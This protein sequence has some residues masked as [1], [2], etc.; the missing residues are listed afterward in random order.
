MEQ[1]SVR[2]LLGKRLKVSRALLLLTVGM[3]LAVISAGPAL[4][5]PADAIYLESLWPAHHRLGGGTGL[6]TGAADQNVAP[7]LHKYDFEFALSADLDLRRNFAREAV[8]KDLMDG[9]FPLAVGFVEKTTTK[10]DW[11]PFSGTSLFYNSTV[12]DTRNFHDVLM[13]STQSTAMGFSQGFGGGTSA[14]TMS[15]SRAVDVTSEPLQPERRSETEKFD[16]ASGLA[17]GWDLKMHLYTTEDNR[18]G[19][20]HQR[21]Y[22]AALQAPMSG[23]AG[24]LALTGKRTVVNQAETKNYKLD[25]VAPFAVRGGKAFAEHHVDYQPGGKQYDKYIVTKFG[26]PLGLFGVRGTIEHTIDETLK[27]ATLTEARTTVVNA[28]FMVDG[29]EIGHTQTMR[30][31]AVNGAKT[32]T[33]RTDLSV[34]IE[35]GRATLERIVTSRPVGDDDEWKQKQTVIKTPKLDIGNIGEVSAQRKTVEIVGEKTTSVDTVNLT[36]IPFSPV[37]LQALW[38]LQD[39]STTSAVKTQHL[40]GRWKLNPTSEVVYNYQEQEVIDASP[41]TVRRLTLETKR[42][43]GLQLSAG[44][45]TYGQDGIE[46]DPAGKLGLV[47]G[48]PSGL[49]MIATYTEYDDQKFTTHGD[50]ANVALTLKHSPSKDKTI[51]LRFADQPGRPEPERG[52]NVGMDALGGQMTLGY[53][54]NA[55]GLDKKVRIA[56]VYDA[57]LKRK[58]FGDLDLSLGLRLCDYD[59]AALAS[60]QHYDLGLSG[61]RENRGGKVTFSYRSGELL[62]PDEKKARTMPA[63]VMNLSFARSWGE[64]GRLSL[65][66]SRHAA[67]NSRPHEDGTLTGV[68]RYN[69]AF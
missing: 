8:T 35:G 54:Q 30:S 55:L 13:N 24:T 57:S 59:D 51:Q 61:G 22:A 5:E 15:F 63:S 47:L 43:E 18:T 39:D 36:A 67:P 64:Q 23:G 45:I 2:N 44:Y 19:G 33:F 11:S 41:T 27:A 62:W 9:A 4:C 16:F 53:S 28:P 20:Y 10:M 17:E 6:I 58:V 65:T 7:D 26:A 1:S 34:P 14:S 66:L 68:L 38:V 37:R 42:G 25:V 52:I 29:K 31:V 46:S 69:M 40:D 60:D 3:A 48:K 21:D 49:Q 32:D 56:D 12:T 50:E